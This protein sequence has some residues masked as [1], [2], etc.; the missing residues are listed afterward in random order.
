MIILQGFADRRVYFILE[1]TH[2][3]NIPE[4]GREIVRG[5]YKCWGYFYFRDDGK[6]WGMMLR[7]KW[8]CTKTKSPKPHNPRAFPFPQ[9]VRLGL[10]YLGR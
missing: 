4:L 6:G 7:G 2:L 9:S 8:D 10:G 3:G 5:L 1:G